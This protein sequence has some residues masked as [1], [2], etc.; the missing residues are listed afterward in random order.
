MQLEIPV[1]T[2]LH[3]CRLARAG[4]AQVILDPAPVPPAAGAD[5]LPDDLYS[6]VDFI[7]PNQSEATALTGLAVDGV[8][9]AAEAGQALVQRGV[10]VAVVK[11]GSGGAVV[12]DGSTGGTRH[13]PAF[14][15]PAVDTTAA[16][17]AFAGALAVALAEGKPLVDALVFASAAGALA[18]TRPGA[19]SSLPFRH[20]IEQLLARPAGGLQPG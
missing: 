12:V 10:G 17:D 2:V 16:G 7:T 20:E 14:A 18:V 3:V 13:L 5:P 15:V 11:L 4:G 19:Q 9:A 8:T 1:E 6:L